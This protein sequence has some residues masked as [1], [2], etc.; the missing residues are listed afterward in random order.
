M[1]QGVSFKP[2]LTVRLLRLLINPFRNLNCRCRIARQGGFQQTCLQLGLV[3]LVS[4]KP[5]LQVPFCSQVVRFRVVA[6]IMGQDEVVAQISR[7]A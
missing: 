5:G 6:A 1:C 2:H 4:L 7:V 3:L